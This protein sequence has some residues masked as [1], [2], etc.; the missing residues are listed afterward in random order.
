MSVITLRARVLQQLWV[1]ILLILA[2]AAFTAL[3]ARLRVDLPFTPVPITLQ[4]LAVLLAGLVLGARA[5]AASQIVYV[6][7]ITLGAPLDAG[8]LGTAVWLR[9]SAGYLPGFIAGAFVAGYLAAPKRMPTRARR[10]IAALAGVL[11]I[12]LVGAT[13][14]TVGFLGG[15]V[16]AGIM[17]GVIPFIGIDL[18]KAFVAAV[19][20]ESGA[21]LVKQWK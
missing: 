21:A 17:Q 5:G 3:T 2:F 13:W 6:L 18:V 4:V 16:T 11:T 20:A 8:G 10:F 19:V 15:N 12:Y 14:L 9:P 1:R 7:A